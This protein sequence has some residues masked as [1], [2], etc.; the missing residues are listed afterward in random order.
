MEILGKFLQSLLP[1]YQ[2]AA[3]VWL[4]LVIL[5]FAGY[6]L[7]VGETDATFSQVN[8]WR[9]SHLI[10]DCPPAEDNCEQ[11]Q[12]NAAIS[13]SVAAQKPQADF[14]DSELIVKVRNITTQTLDAPGTIQLFLCQGQETCAENAPFIQFFRKEEGNSWVPSNRMLIVPLMAYEEKVQV[15]RVHFEQVPADKTQPYKLSIRAGDDQQIIPLKYEVLVSWDPIT[16]F[17]LWLSENLLVP[18][19]ANVVLFILSLLLLGLEDQSANF[20]YP[21]KEENKRH[22]FYKGFIAIFSLIVFPVLTY[23]LPEVVRWHIAVLLVL[24][25]LFGICHG[26]LRHRFLTPLPEVDKT[27]SLPASSG[28]K[29]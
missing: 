12:N 28:E 15:F 21:V 24:M 29:Q 19:A 14:L 5:L 9:W 10:F 16:V 3:W 11:E 8:K 13:V 4:G 7:P 1:K 26:W 2:N 22:W 18:P 20:S 23:L 6:Y 25:I 27:Q 17:R